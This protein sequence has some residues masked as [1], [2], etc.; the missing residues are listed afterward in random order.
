MN[1]W[2]EYSSGSIKEVSMFKIQIMVDNGFRGERVS[3]FI[4]C[5]GDEIE[6]LNEGHNVD[7]VKVINRAFFISM[8]HKDFEKDVRLWCATIGT[9]Q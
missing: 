2:M 3:D 8:S 7:I 5:V 6:I 4:P 9:R 1:H